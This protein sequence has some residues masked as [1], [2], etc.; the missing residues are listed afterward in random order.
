MASL[1]IKLLVVTDT[2][3]PLRDGVLKCVEEFVERSKEEFDITLLVPKLSRKKFKGMKTIFFNVSKRLKASMYPVVSLTWSNLRTIKKAVKESELVFSHGPATVGF[4][5]SAY[6]ALRFGKKSVFYIHNTGW[7]FLEKYF[8]LGRFTS[9][10]IKRF[11]VWIYNRWDLLLVP[12]REVKEE[13]E[14][15]GVKTEIEVARLGVDIERFSPSKDKRASKSRLNL[16][17][18]I[19]IGYVG[20]ICKEKNTLVLLEAFKKLN[21]K[22]F[23]LL[24][25]GDGT[26]EIVKEFKENKNCLVTGF[27]GNV[28]D[29]MQAMDIF[30][31]PS[32]TE[33]TSLATL[34]AMSSGLP[35][36]ATKVGFIKNYVVKSYNGI[37][38]PRNS[39]SLLAMKINR[40]AGDR[41]LREKLGQNAR[42][43]VAYSFSWERSISKMKRLM[44]K[45]YH[46][47]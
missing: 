4:F 25:V 1:K 2:Y 30:V 39:A 20:R 38:F 15:A 11:F 41:N 6:Y 18:K 43:T 28:E 23:F 14:E 19:I 24:M 40:L 34:E 10:V 32:L 27:V 37:F 12:Y 29:Y 8:G 5:I 35:V 36:I 3:F 33:T 9:K 16:P 44:H 17:H 31:M 7:E 46:G 22:K 45:F 13:L 47:G 42:K 21:Q 26:E